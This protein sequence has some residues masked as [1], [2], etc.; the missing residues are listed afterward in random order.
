MLS[1]HKCLLV[2]KNTVIQSVVQGFHVAQFPRFGK[3]IRIGQTRK[4]YQPTSTVEQQDE[5]TNEMVPCRDAKRGLRINDVD[6]Q[7]L[8][9]SIYKQI[10]KHESPKPAPTKVEQSLKDLQKHGMI[11][12]K[13]FDYMPDINFN[14]PTLRGND[15]IEHF[16]IIGEQQAKPYRDL[17]L[18]L[19]KYIPPKPSKW[20][21]QPGWTRYTADSEPEIVPYPL[22][23]AFVFDVE[24]CVKSG[25]APTLATAVSN[26]AWYGW[27]SASVLDGTSKPVTNHQ[28]HQDAL[29]PLESK[30][31]E[32]GFNLNL[33]FLQPKIVIGHNVSYDRARIKEQYWLEPTAVRF[34]DT[35]SLH[36]CIAGLTSYQRTVLKSSEESV[37]EDETWK[38]VSSLNNLSDVHKLYCGTEIEK[39]TRN[40]F[41]EGSLADVKKEFQNVMDYCARDVQATYGI[42]QNMFPIFLERFPHPVTFA[43]MLELSTAYLPVN[44]NWERYIDDSEQAYEDLDIEGRFTLARRADQACQLLHNNQYEENIWMWDQDWAVKDIKMKKN[45]PKT[46]RSNKETKCVSSEKEKDEIKEE[47]EEEIDYLEQKFKYLEETSKLLPAVKTLLPGYPNWYRKLCTKPDS[48]PDWVPGPHLISTSMQITP[49]LLNL[50]WE[51]YPLHFIRGKGWGLLVPFVEKTEQQT[52]LPLKQIVERC[53]VVSSKSGEASS[54]DIRIDKSVDEHLSKREYYRRLKK[55]KTKG[56]YKGW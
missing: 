49:K 9:K 31:N 40:I 6:I 3:A 55:D 23:D 43:G 48:S 39:D 41:L 15:V 12:G 14:I 56:I 21:M 52:K 19:L 26:S 4:V 18:K 38:T 11:K 16:H 27:V 29:I 13:D 30:P 8:S 53:P 51:G 34:L 1:K 28:Y 37:E 33:K 36:I 45:L 17:V 24:V 2:G 5:I 35:M 44:S 42:L 20:I 22:E 46:K 10:F 47:E 50:T 54:L 7:M 25:K 32:R